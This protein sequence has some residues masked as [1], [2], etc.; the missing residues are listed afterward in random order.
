METTTVG[1]ISNRAED[2]RVL[3]QQLQNDDNHLS[4]RR[5]ETSDGSS[6]VPRDTVTLSGAARDGEPAKN[7]VTPREKAALLG[8]QKVTRFSVYG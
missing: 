2:T 1:K 8:S 3:R 6:P 7:P 4:G 5:R